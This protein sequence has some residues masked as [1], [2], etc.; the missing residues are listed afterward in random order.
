MNEKEYIE[1]LR[2]ELNNRVSLGA[3]QIMSRIEKENDEPV[4]VIRHK[5]FHADIPAVAACAVFAFCITASAMYLDAGRKNDMQE[6]SSECHLYTTS[7]YTT[8]VSPVN[9]PST[10][11]SFI[12]Q[13]TVVSPISDINSRK[14]AVTDTSDFSG[15]VSETEK[16]AGVTDSD[17][18]SETENSE[19]VSVTETEYSGI[20]EI[21]TQGTEVTEGDETG[22]VSEITG[23]DESDGEVLPEGIDSESHPSGWFK[24]CDSLDNTIDTYGDKIAVN[25]ITVSFGRAVN[26]ITDD[27]QSFYIHEVKTRTVTMKDGTLPPSEKINEAKAPVYSSS[28]F[29]KLSKKGDNIYSINL[30]ND[31]TVAY[32]IL[33]NDSNVLSID[34]T[35]IIYKSP[36]FLEAIVFKNSEEFNNKESY[37]KFYN[38]YS[39]LNLTETVEDDW[40]YRMQ[41]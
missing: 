5:K 8:S 12:P 22:R 31:D 40:G 38:E 37:E 21:I 11:T 1:G 13:N 32:D 18:C 25:P 19:M 28:L 6:F 9:N 20:G 4:R 27:L 39:V 26:I 3:D 41:G 34:E 23:G 14:P 10:S 16:N 24:L 36:L 2:K 33:M 30:A 17:K 29:T 35:T 7:S 15:I